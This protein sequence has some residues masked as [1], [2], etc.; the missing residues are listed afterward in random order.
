MQFAF[1]AARPRHRRVAATLAFMAALGPAFALPA[2]AETRV[3]ARYAV[4]VAG[5]DI[6]TATMQTGI[7]TSTYDINLSVRMSGLVKFITGGKAAATSRGSYGEARVVPAAYAINTRAKDKGQVIRFALAGGS[8]RQLSVEPPPKP[9]SNVIPVTEADKRNIVDPLSAVMMPVSGGGDPLSE[10]ACDRTLPVFDGRQ[11]YDV[12]LRYDR[13]E[14]AKPDTSENADPNA[15]GNY[16]GK[17]VV[18]RASYKA[19]AGHRPDKDNVKFM[20]NN[21]EMEVWMAPVAGTRALMPWK[22][23]V[24]TQYGLAVITATSF[25]VDEGK[26]GQGKAGGGKGVDL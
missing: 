7:G 6:G 10:K 5:F 25:V 2:A 16:E 12:A 8:V 18:C 26:V 3:R 17:L 15:K 21:K 20:E 1:P 9:N 14:T 24:R 4:S 13:M 23:S 22:I 11:R 19:I